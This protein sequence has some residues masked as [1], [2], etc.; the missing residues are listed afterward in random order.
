MSEEN[1]NYR[2][3]LDELIEK[4]SKFQRAL[5]GDD[6]D[7]FQS[8]LEHAKKHATA[9]VNQDHPVPM[10]SFL[11]SI[12]LEQQKMIDRLKKKLEGKGMEL[13]DY[14]Y[15]KVDDE[16]DMDQKDAEAVDK[17]IKRSE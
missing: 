9:G 17:M 13:E 15:L 1:K 14:S 2:E 10:E 8:L 12:L 3:E 7:D 5:R 4:W 11:L 16:R 6:K